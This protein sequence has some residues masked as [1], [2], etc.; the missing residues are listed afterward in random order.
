MARKKTKV[1]E[2]ALKGWISPSR[3]ILQPKITPKEGKAIMTEEEFD[4]IWYGD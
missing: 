4:K 2:Q 3:E 1:N